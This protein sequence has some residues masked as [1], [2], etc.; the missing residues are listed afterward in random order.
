MRGSDRSLVNNL[1]L[2]AI[3]LAIAAWPGSLSAQMAA[4]QR[5]TSSSDSESL[6]AQGVS[7]LERNDLAEAKRIFLK[8]IVLNA[9]DATA[10]MYLGI[11]Y[12]RTGDLRS[13]ESHFAAAVRADPRSASAH[14]NYGVSLL[15]LGRTKEAATEFVTSLNIDRNQ[16]NA[17]INLGQL[18]LNSGS[19]AELSEAFTLF[20]LAYKL[21][22]DAETARAL[23]VVSLR[24]GKRDVASGYYRE[25][26]ARLDQE[27][28]VKPSGANRAELGG[29]LLENTLVK[30]ALLELT[31][32]VD[33]EPANTDAILRLARA[34]LAANNIPQAGRVLESAVARGIDPAP[35][36]AL[37]AT[38]YEK[39]NHIE[40][41]IPAMRLAI[42]RDPTSETYRFSYGML[43]IS[44]LAPEA[45]VIRLKE[46]LELFPNSSRLWLA[47]GIA[48]FKAGRNDEATKCLNKSIDLDSKYAPAFVYLGMTQVETGDY[49]HAIPSYEEGLRLNPKL[50][51]VNFLIADVMMKQTDS[52]YSVIESH[53]SKAVQSDP[54]LAPA[55]LALGKLYLRK[56]RLIEAASEFEKVIALEPTVA[57]AY[58]QLGLTYRRLK[59]NEEA[60][61]LLDKFKS[62][63]ESQKEQ[64][65][66]DRKDI[67]NR[68]ATVLF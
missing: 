9:K 22:P 23:I 43:L 21:K 62:L 11:V 42:Q 47:L 51:I 26:S 25:Y 32:A 33:A 18:R 38:V 39:G 49:K 35:I 58:Y 2:L 10:H 56:T 44:A 3:C 52:D 8:A 6:I 7:A 1:T 68:L 55:R 31:A 17:L 28:V 50:S 65:S 61:A 27:D 13:A 46:A 64:A 53:L 63:S 4:T 36:Y 14:N 15:K 57:E 60:T 37:L 20:E 59:R 19:P 48:H 66:K 67:I 40:N 5:T 16:A 24:L 45:A 12:D 54:K 41:A 34:H 30:E 29:A